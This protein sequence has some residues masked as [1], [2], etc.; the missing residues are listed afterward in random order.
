MFT[1]LPLASWIGLVLVIH[2]GGHN[3]RSSILIASIL[4]L[5]STSASDYGG[6]ELLGL[7]A[8][9]SLVA[10]WGLVAV[11]VAVVYGGLRRRTSRPAQIRASL[12]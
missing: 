8:F 7:V 5:Q 4:W 10:L 11:T 9:P 12:I 3:W 6:I 1:A 2:A